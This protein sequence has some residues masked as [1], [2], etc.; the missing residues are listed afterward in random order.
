MP[1][2]ECFLQSA[3]S[4][5][6]RSPL[7]KTISNE[8]VHP[9][10]SVLPCTP[11]TSILRG[12]VPR[13]NPAMKSNEWSEHHLAPQH[14]EEQRILERILEREALA[15]STHPYSGYHSYEITCDS[16]ACACPPPEV[17]A[18]GGW[19]HPSY[20]HVKA[21]SFCLL[22]SFGMQPWRALRTARTATPQCPHDPYPSHF[23]STLVQEGR[24]G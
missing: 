10:L 1:E 20:Q 7:L 18:W 3:Q 23:N 24:H 5:Q 2:K 4:D 22:P 17:L 8:T 21:I 13:G 9:V 11:N 15:S 12:S 19:R 6:A 14:E 16:Q